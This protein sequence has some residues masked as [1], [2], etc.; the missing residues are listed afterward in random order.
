MTENR[1]IDPAEQ[2]PFVPVKNGDPRD[3]LEVAAQLA[4]GEVGRG[5]RVNEARAGPPEM[6]E[7]GIIVVSRL[8]EGD[9][10]VIRFAPEL[11][12]QEVAIAFD[13]LDQLNLAATREDAMATCM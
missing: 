1:A 10:E 5:S 6:E 13:L 3:D 12:L 7:C 2:V 4:R 9:R 8:A 11:P